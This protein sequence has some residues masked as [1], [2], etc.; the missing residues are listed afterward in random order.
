M[1]AQEKTI[2]IAQ[3][4]QR[5]AHF[6]N[7]YN[8]NGTAAP[9]PKHCQHTEVAT[10]HRLCS[11]KRTAKIAR[12]INDAVLQVLLNWYMANKTNFDRYIHS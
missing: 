12:N 9:K 5:H 7:N 4:N 8:Y 1:Q 2:T 10:A 3:K 11:N 6:I